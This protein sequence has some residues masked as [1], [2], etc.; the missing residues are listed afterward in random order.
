[1]RFAV[2][3]SGDA[4]F[5]KILEKNP[6]CFPNAVFALVIADRNCQGYAHFSLSAVPAEYI[7]YTAYESKDAF[8][9]K[10]AATLKAYS[11]D[12]LFLNYKRLIGPT[13]LNQYP[14]SIINLHL[15]PLPF[16]KGIHGMKDSFKS[17]ILFSGATMHIVDESI[18]GGPIISQVIFGRDIQ[19]SEKVFVQRLFD[20]AAI[21]SIDTIHKISTYPLQ[22]REQRWIFEGA[23]YDNAPFNPSLSIDRTRV[24]L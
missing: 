10:V 24:I 8:E 11:I 9:Q 19:E 22:Q 17:D 16:F 21:L 20:H 4:S 2:M 23:T 1:M 7:E 5:A 14:R 13:L 18:D 12:L 3:I 6:T 15:A